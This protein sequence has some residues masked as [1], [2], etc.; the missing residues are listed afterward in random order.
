MYVDKDS[1]GKYSLQD[2]TLDDIR[3]LLSAIEDSDA[4]IYNPRFIQ[5]INEMYYITKNPSLWTF[6]NE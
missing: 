3:D 2:M 1:R 6:L 4:G 5:L